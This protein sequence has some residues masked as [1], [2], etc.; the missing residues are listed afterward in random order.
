MKAVLL[1]SILSSALVYGE[2]HGTG[3][4]VPKDWQEK[5]EVAFATVAS[6]TF[7]VANLPERY[8]WREQVENP[9][10]IVNQGG[11]GSC[12]AFGTTAVLRWQIAIN[13][14]ENVGLSEQEILSC[15]NKGSCRGGYFA[16]TYQEAKGQSE[17]S[18]FPYTGRD[19]KCKTGLSNRY[20]VKSWG[21]IGGKNRAPSVSE[22]KYYLYNYGPV[23]VTITSNGALQSFR[24]AGIFRSCTRGET[25]HIVHIVGWD[26]KDGVWIVGN[27]W[28]TNWG[29]KGYFKIPFG[30]SRVGEIATYVVY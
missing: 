21:Y 12:W 11:C 25:N 17:S 30:C 13:R 28:G 23:G 15:S 5:E 27:S 8:D 24:G 2:K 7:K 10:S 18:E 1:F 16:H 14:G 22:I 26:D 3:L 6:S 29:N 20:P 19:S 4:I 9:P